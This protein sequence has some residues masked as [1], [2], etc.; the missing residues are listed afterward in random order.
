[1]TPDLDTGV[2]VPCST[3]EGGELFGAFA[4]G[5]LLHTAGDVYAPGVQSADCVAD[6]FRAQTACHNQLQS[7]TRLGKSGTSDVSVVGDA[8][9]TDPVCSL[10]PQR[11]K[12][13]AILAGYN[14]AP[15]A[16]LFVKPAW[17]YRPNPA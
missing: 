9:S 2:R 17:L 11:P 5:R 3:D 13:D 15:L 14:T 6:V 4:A 1:L 7:G 16:Q 8:A 12:V 10:A